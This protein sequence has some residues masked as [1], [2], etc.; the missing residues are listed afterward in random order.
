MSRKIIERDL[1][2]F[3]ALLYFLAR[4]HRSLLGDVVSEALVEQPLALP[5]PD[6]AVQAMPLRRLEAIRRLLPGRS[7][8]FQ[9]LGLLGRLKPLMRCNIP[10]WLGPF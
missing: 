2:R 10:S 5:G 3:E 4:L 6:S 8:A 7:W 9:E 1:A